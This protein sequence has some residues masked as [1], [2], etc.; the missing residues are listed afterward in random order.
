MLNK[1]EENGEAWVP[2]ECD[3]SIRSGWFYS[4]STDTSL[5]SVDKLMD[6]YYWASPDTSL[7]PVINLNFKKS[8]TFNRLLL[9]EYIALGQRVKS[10][11]V[12]VL[13]IRAVQ[14]D[15]ERND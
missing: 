4:P 6:I 1:G 14:R 8:V 2:A 3:V 12:E 9:Q 11:R 7:T 5:K 15:S 10:F 13:E